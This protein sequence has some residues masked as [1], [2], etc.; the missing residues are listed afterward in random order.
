MLPVSDRTL[1]C[2]KKIFPPPEK[3]M[4]LFRTLSRLE[5]DFVSMPITF[6]SKSGFLDYKKRHE[7]GAVERRTANGVVDLNNVDF[8]NV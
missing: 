2:V 7:R 4:V 8:W 3:N 5:R 6:F 1:I